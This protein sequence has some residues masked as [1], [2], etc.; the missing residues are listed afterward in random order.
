MVMLRNQHGFLACL[1]GVIIGNV[2]STLIAQTADPAAQPPPEPKPAPLPAQSD[3]GVIK[4][5]SPLPENGTV[6]PIV[7]WHPEYEQELAYRARV[8]GYERQLNKIRR[9]FFGIR[10]LAS[11]RQQ[12]FDE[13]TEF[14][15]PA[16][17][18]PMVKVFAREKDDVRLAVLDHLAQQDEDGMAVLAW[19]AITDDDQAI[20]HEASKR[21]ASPASD[22]VLEQLDMALRSPDHAVAMHAAVLAGT[23]DAVEVIPLL[24][25][26]QAAGVPAAQQTGDL[27]WIAIETQRAYVAGVVA[28]AGDASGAFQP[29]IGKISEGAI[30]RIVD[31]VVI[32][33]RTE[34]HRTLVAMTSNDWD[35]PTDGLNYNINAWWHWYNEEYVPFKNEQAL[36][37]D[38]E[39]SPLLGISSLSKP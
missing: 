32:V 6:P 39:A 20:R 17:F 14:T 35:Q 7:Q 22:R 21:L 29:I 37:A 26:A 12:G 28:V 1:C 10:K 30:L 25:F 34:V 8:R 9:K 5:L 36:L 33:Y 13:L 23:L 24:I 15:D 18:K 31:A 16:A 38:L 27:A 4:Y 3:T 2:S 19:I 11:L